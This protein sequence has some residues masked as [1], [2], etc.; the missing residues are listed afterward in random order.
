MCGRF[1]LEKSIGN[2]GSLFQVRGVAE[3]PERYN[4]APTQPIVA[5]RQAEAGE[6]RELV[7]L[8]WGLIPAWAKEPAALPLL[9]NARSETAAAKPAFRAA[10]RRRRCL[11]PADGFYE[12]QRREGRKQPYHMRRRD[13]AP[14]ALAG[15]WERWEG[16]DG[17]ID[18][19]AL[20][21]T[22]SNALMR[23]IHD[24]MPV[25]LD[26]QSFDLW[27]DPRM[28]DVERVQS[29]LRPYPAEA[30]IAYPV[31]AMVN[32]ARNDNPQCVLPLDS[33]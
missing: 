18:S 19:C 12:W 6:E 17:A 31:S 1:T 26:P 22:A 9:I 33:D 30:M 20:L 21:T 24:R 8:R 16:P 13:G 23:P 3:L 25:I 11:V 15:L 32:N 4:I 10:L 14:F 5:I 7:L 29:L 28:Q 27:L 2:L